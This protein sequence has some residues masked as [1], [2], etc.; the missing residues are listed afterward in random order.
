MQSFG[1]IIDM[2]KNK[3]FIRYMVLFD[4]LHETNIVIMIFLTGLLKVKSK[5]NIKWILF[6]CLLLDCNRSMV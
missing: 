1:R 2:I 3:F 4:G 5:I 6:D